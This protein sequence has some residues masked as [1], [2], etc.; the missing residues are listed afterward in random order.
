MPPLVPPTLETERLILRPFALEDAP[1][2]QLLAGDR[3]VASTT[4]R[5]PHPYTAV[6]AEEWIATHPK[7][8]AEGK[9]IPLAIV[10]AASRE[11]IGA[12]GLEIQTDHQRAELGYWVGTP[13]WGK[14]Y[15]TE[16]ARVM[17]RYGFDELGLNRV[18]AHYLARNPA[19][20]RVL[21][22][23]GMK[24]EGLLRKHIKKWGTFEDLVAFGVLR[25]EL[26]ATP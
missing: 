1:R 8:M 21:E 15:C 22:K 26:A 11:L 25:D 20:G 23:I 10:L 16:A 17:V 18:V 24:R 5:I 9:A 3:E 12:I 6:L 14:G 13:Y 19:S 4:L 2:V 7:L